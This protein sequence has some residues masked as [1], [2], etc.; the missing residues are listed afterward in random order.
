MER[1][2]AWYDT[3]LDWN[4]PT[5]PTPWSPEEG[6]RFKRAAQALLQQLQAQLGPAYE[7]GD[8]FKVLDE[9]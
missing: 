3:S 5:G 4:D 7:I 9:A 8:E 1:L 6:A 2:A